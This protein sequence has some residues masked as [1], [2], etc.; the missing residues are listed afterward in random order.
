MKLTQLRNKLKTSSELKLLDENA[1]ETDDISAAKDL[2]LDSETISLDELT[3]YKV[4]DVQLCLRVVVH[5]W[6]HKDSSAA[7]Y[8]ADCQSKQLTNVSFLQRNDLI[9]WLSGE[10][11]VSQYIVEGDDEATAKNKAPVVVVP[12]SED[13]RVLKEIMLHERCLADHNSSLRGTKSRN[14][15]YLIKEAELKI[16]HPLKA[17]RRSK[18]AAG[19]SKDAGARP[20]PATDPIILIPSAASSIFT[21]SN[22]KQFLENSQYIHPKDLSTVKNDLTSVVKKFDRIS[23]P[24][25]FLIVNSTRLFTKPEY[26]NR[27][28]AIFTTG[29]EWQF[30]NYQWSNPTDLFQRCKGYYFHF[31]GDVI[32]KHVDQWNVQ[33]VELEKNKRFKDLEVLRFFWNTMEKELLARG[34]H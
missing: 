26:W 5:C 31:A 16:V 34:Y 22:I 24:I 17:S 25:K 10:S 21:I 23:R 9:Q 18:V 1:Q 20:S 3:D 19:I 6:L 2:K 11:Q 12:E 30:K 28:V 15:G 4:E 29:H 14:F 8:L 7:D 27:V 33:K 13:D 32:P